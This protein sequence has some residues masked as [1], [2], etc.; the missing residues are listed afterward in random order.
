VK[1]RS[2]MKFL[3]ILV[4]K[5]VLILI[6]S[7]GSAINSEAQSLDS[8]RATFEQGEVFTSGFE[9][10]YKDTFTG[11]NQTT[12]GTIWIDSSQYKIISGNSIMVVDGEVS[13]VYDS[14]KDRVIISEYVEE[15]DDFAPSRMLQGVD[16]SYTISE[17]PVE[18]GG[19]RI[20]MVS[21]DP[22]SIF[23]EVFIRLNESGIPQR[24]EAIDQVENELVTTFFDGK[25]ISSS[26]SLFRFPNPEGAEVIDLRHE[27]R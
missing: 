2:W 16:S 20:Q 25:F 7:M 22:F 27:S 24:I 23:S 13:Y 5:T 21:D 6:L 26:D 4:Y 11:E 9:H 17:E 12:T 15:D 3:K 19:V 1:R 10:I 14:T 8:L 18:E